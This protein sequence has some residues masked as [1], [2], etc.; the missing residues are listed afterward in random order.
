MYDLVPDHIVTGLDGK[1]WI[2]GQRKKSKEFFK[3]PLLPQAKAIVEKYQNHPLAQINGK[4][5][6]VYTNQKTN[7]YLKEIA[8]LC[9]VKKNLTFHLARH[10]FATTVTLANGVPIE[11]VS[12]MLGHTS[13]R[14]TQ[15]YAKVVEQ[16][17]SNDMDQLE[18]ILVS[19]SAKSRTGFGKPPLKFFLVS[20]IIVS[21]AYFL[22]LKYNLLEPHDG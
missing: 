6:P 7:A 18:E 2:H 3:V 22:N 19:I 5:L 17:L 4:V 1:L 13:L 9:E 15:I 14:T 8:F 10:T 12:K 20:V 16:K 11:S 21:N